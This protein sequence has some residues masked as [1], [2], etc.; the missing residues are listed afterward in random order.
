MK[1]YVCR[2][3]EH[4]NSQ[5]A[6]QSLLVPYQKIVSCLVS[7]QGS[8]SNQLCDLGQYPTSSSEDT[9][10]GFYSKH[11]GKSRGGFKQKSNR[12]EL[13]LEKPLRL[14]CGQWIESR[15]RE[16]GASSQEAS[17][18]GRRSVRGNQSFRPIRK[19]VMA[20][21]PGGQVG[22]SQYRQRGEERFEIYFG[23]RDK[24]TFSWVRIAATKQQ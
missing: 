5:Q 23:G 4:V 1:G 6:E 13:C 21:S 3:Q 14:Q 16:S 22:L 24:E 18:S 9:E 12:C 11:I 20:G 8:I 15:E 7:K 2:C 19:V 17:T 10:F